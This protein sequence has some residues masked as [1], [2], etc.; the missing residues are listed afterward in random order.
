[1]SIPGSADPTAA[2]PAQSGPCRLC[3]SDRLRERHQIR[4]VRVD[5][6]RDCGFIQVR[7]QP[8]PDDL[9]ELY[10]R[11]YFEHGKY[12]DAFA[13]GKEHE[14]RLS[15]LGRHVTSGSRVLD[16]GCA[17]G[18]FVE[19]AAGKYEMWGL[20]ISAFAIEQ[21]K[22]RLP[23]LA[24]RLRSGLVEDQDYPEG[25]FDAVVMWDV[26]E[27]LW[28]PVEACRKLLRTLRPGGH[29]VLST[30]NISAATARLM[31]RYWAFM[32]VPEHLGFCGKASMRHLLERRLGLEMVHWAS[33]G[34]WA[35]LGFV[36][37]KVKR[38]APRLVPQPAV[39]L[40]RTRPLNRLA[41]YVPTKDIQYVVAR[42]PTERPT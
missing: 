40:L 38:I 24:D 42:K 12:S 4:A 1:M 25:F 27:H 28:D 23:W 34:K 22:A 8:R 20:D 17:T 19:Y 29:L 3:G 11:A 33:K 10:G 9:L 18:E 30:P 36:L 14:R 32:T 5:E 7:E 41:L 6:C 15:L 39:N 31:G 13:L 2:P 26:L 37:Y 16:A 21:A 35:N